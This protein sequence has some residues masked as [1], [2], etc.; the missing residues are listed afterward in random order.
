MRVAVLCQLL[1]LAYHQTTTL[2]DLYPFNGVRNSSQR[3]R[4]PRAGTLTE[5]SRE[6]PG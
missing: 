6:L 2:V 1:L 4:I 3:E 5:V